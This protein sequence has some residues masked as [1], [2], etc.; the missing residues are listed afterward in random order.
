[1]KCIRSLI[2]LT[3]GAYRQ[4]FRLVTSEVS[5]WFEDHS[6]KNPL[7]LVPD[8]NITKTVKGSKFGDP[9]QLKIIPSPQV[10]L[11]TN[12]KIK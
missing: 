6:T 3:E 9:N 11:Y 10:K 1:M 5:L 4:Y 2:V 7:G 8:P 12:Y